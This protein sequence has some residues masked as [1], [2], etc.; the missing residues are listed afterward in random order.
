MIDPGKGGLENA[1]P[2]FPIYPYCGA[3][4]FMRVVGKKRMCVEL[5]LGLSFLKKEVRLKLGEFRF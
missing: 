2:E 4:E 5:P 1:T 3:P